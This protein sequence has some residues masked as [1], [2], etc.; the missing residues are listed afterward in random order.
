M[1]K[2]EIQSPGAAH[3]SRQQY[4]RLFSAV[5]SQA[6]SERFTLVVE[7]ECEK[8]RH[9]VP[10][11]KSELLAFLVAHRIDAEW[12]LENIV[13][14]ETVRRRGL[15]ALL[16]GELIAHAR[17]EGS[18]SIFLEVRDS[19]QSA[20]ALYRKIG[21]EETGLRKSYYASPP[22]DAIICRLSLC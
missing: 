11:E 3:W 17:T 6:P 12:E 14:S 7:N 18:S 16:L 2:L 22:E 20:R 9:G 21:F 4:E 13:V 5:D 1:M 8:R 19:N 10:D 15:A